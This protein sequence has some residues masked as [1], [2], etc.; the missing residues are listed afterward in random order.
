MIALTI[1]ALVIATVFTIGGSSARNFA[2]QQRVGQLQLSTRL[3]LDRVRRDVERAGLH[4][5]P[6]SALETTCTVPPRAVQAVFVDDNATSSRGALNVFD[7]AAS[8]TTTQADLLRLVGNFATSDAYLVRSFN[9]TGNVAF[10]QTAWQGFRRSFAD[11]VADPT[12]NTFDASLFS[13]VFSAGRMLHI[14][15]THGRHF[16][17]TVSSA[18]L[19]GPNATVTF[20]PAIPIGDTSGCMPGLGE[21]AMIAPLAQIQYELVSPP[22][23]LPAARDA[24]VT[25][26]NVGLVRREID[27]ASGA[28]ISQRTVLEWAVHFDVD[29]ILDD[30]PVGNVPD[31]RL[32]TFYDDV[33]AENQLTVRPQRARALVVTLG[34]RTPEQDA[35]FP[36]VAPVATDPLSRFRVF[37]TRPGAARVRT[38]TAEISLPNLVYRGL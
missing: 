29:A 35:D 20:S 12:G 26:A 8:N 18:T 13:T 1:G 36:W 27:M 24:L 19:A 5:T 28:V 32:L 23:D 15:N 6:S 34:A 3:A 16:F 22:P 17:V 2:E 21:G 25:G 7:A 11:V 14:Q 4:G 38:A 33:A 31:A 37:A 9:A 30:T 10:L